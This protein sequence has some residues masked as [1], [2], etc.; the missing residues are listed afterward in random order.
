M[1]NRA[2]RRANRDAFAKYQAEQ[3]ARLTEIPREE[4]PAPTRNHPRGPVRV[5]R[6]RTLLVQEFSERAPAI[7]R[8]SI[9][10]AALN[11]DGG[12]RDG[13]SWEEL[14]AIKREV[15]F[16]DQEAIEIY[17]RDADVVNVANMRH[18]WIIPG[19]QVGWFGAL[20]PI[21]DG[22]RGG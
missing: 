10:R 1:M 8:L 14:Q 11:E 6:S 2:L 9:C 21:E 18:L 4:W 15:G 7:C 3:P 22:A 5:W 13:L 17:P 16:G 19:R 20:A 12:W